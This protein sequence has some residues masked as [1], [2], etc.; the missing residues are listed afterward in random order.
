MPTHSGDLPKTAACPEDLLHSRW[1]TSDPTRRCPGIDCHWHGRHDELISGRRGWFEGQRG[2]LHTLV[3]SCPLIRGPEEPGCGSNNSR[4]AALVR[5]HVYAG[6]A[7][8]ALA[9]LACRLRRPSLLTRKSLKTGIPQT[10]QRGP[11]QKGYFSDA[12]VTP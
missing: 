10:P 9:A 5:T 3:A 2:Q 7:L 8:A 1:R 6:A 12:S 11:A 4:L